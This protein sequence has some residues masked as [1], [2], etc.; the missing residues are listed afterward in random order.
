MKGIFFFFAFC[1][2]R[3][4]EEAQVIL[5]VNV[6]LWQKTD[7]EIYESNCQAI[8][9]IFL[10]SNL[11][12]DCVLNWFKNRLVCISIFPNIPLHTWMAK[13]LQFP[14]WLY[15]TPSKVVIKLPST[16]H[17]PGHSAS[18][19]D[20]FASWHVLLKCNSY[21]QGHWSCFLDGENKYHDIKKSQ[22]ELK[23]LV[24]LYYTIFISHPTSQLW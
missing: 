6:N 21:V 19:Q 2:A 4:F 1:F 23:H 10:N 13:K 22:H 7:A 18:V 14:G 3:N 9:F 15:L 12:E 8:C 16:L 17:R 5:L 11:K 24:K 20:H